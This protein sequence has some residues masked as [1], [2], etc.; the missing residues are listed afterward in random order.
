MNNG[1]QA[2]ALHGRNGDT[3]LAHVTVGEIVLFSMI[4]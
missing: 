3:E 2:L 1:L 4:C